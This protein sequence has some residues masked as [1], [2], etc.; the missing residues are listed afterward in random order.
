MQEIIEITKNVWMNMVLGRICF[1]IY[2][3]REGVS[4]RIE[5]PPGRE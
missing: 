4:F 2:K 5:T 1:N 3:I